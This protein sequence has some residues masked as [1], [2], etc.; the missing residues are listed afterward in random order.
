MIPYTIVLADDHALFREGVKRILESEPS[1]KVVGEAGDGIELMDLLRK[2]LPDLVIL[3]ISMPRH[4]GLKSLKEIKTAYPDVKVLILTMYKSAG[5]LLMAFSC[6]ADGYL[7]KGNVCSDL[8]NAIVNIREGKTFISNLMSN[9]IIDLFCKKRDKWA[10]EKALTPRE[11]AVLELL[12]KGE[13]GKQIAER[14]SLSMATIYN[15]RASLKKKLNIGSTAGLVKYALEQGIV[16]R[17][18]ELG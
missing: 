8:F 4:D 9:Q 5:E 16:H 17:E 6:K 12:C 7:W 11:L 2:S 3:D 18:V 15:E 1:L 13:S 14:L 10:T